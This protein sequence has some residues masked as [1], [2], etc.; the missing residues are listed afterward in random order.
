MCRCRS[1]W[2]CRKTR[3]AIADS[4]HNAHTQ[5]RVYGIRHS[6]ET[7]NGAMCLWR[8]H[9]RA[10]R[11]HFSHQH[12][13]KHPP[14]FTHTHTHSKTCTRSQHIHRGASC[15]VHVHDVRRRY[16]KFLKP[17]RKIDKNVSLFLFFVRHSNRWLLDVGGRGGF[18]SHVH[19]FRI[20][21][22]LFS[23]VS[24]RRSSFVF[25][26]AK[27]ETTSRTVFVRSVV[28]SYMR[29]PE[30]VT[31][32]HFVFIRFCVSSIFPDRKTIQ[33][34]RFFC[35]AIV[36]LALSCLCFA[37]RTYSGSA[38]LLQAANRLQHHGECETMQ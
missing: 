30:T 21:F 25:V 23:N 27:S 17:N 10:R 18:S 37:V 29:Q 34:V 19:F 5:C 20:L 24:L 9:T 3:I 35:S 13:V 33:T 16:P 22:S 11:V 32:S 7:G 6:H 36:S 31:L 28:R 26:C 38:R 8:Q 15:S 4:R 2:K 12:T 14:Q 1:R